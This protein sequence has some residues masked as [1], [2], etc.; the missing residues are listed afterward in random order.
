M[1][2][3][4][5]AADW[6][7]GD[8]CQELWTLGGETLGVGVG[9]NPVSKLN[10]W[11]QATR[12]RDAEYATSLTKDNKFAEMLNKYGPD[13]VAVLPSLAMAAFT[14][15]ATAAAST[16]NAGNLATR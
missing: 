1:G 11:V 7:L 2:S 10:S 3:I 13:A 9:K 15:P 5:G 12:K 14:A 16:L 8:F 4:T 6:L